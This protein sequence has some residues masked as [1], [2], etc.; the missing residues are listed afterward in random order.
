MP[1]ITARIINKH[2][3]E[4]NWAL[5][6]NFKPLAGEVIVYDVDSN[7]AYPRFKVG[8]GSTNVNDL[9]FST[10]YAGLIQKVESVP[11]SVNKNSPSFIQT[12]NGNVYYKQD[13]IIGTWVFNDTLGTVG[14]TSVD[15]SFQSTGTWNKIT[16][17]IDGTGS[18][19][20]IKYYKGT[21]TAPLT[22]YRNGSWR[23]DQ[24]KTITIVDVP[25][26]D[27]SQLASF[28][29]FLESNATRTDGGP[30]YIQL[31]SP[32][33]LATNSIKMDNGTVLGSIYGPLDSN[34]ITIPTISG[35]AGANGTDGL[36]ALTCSYII[37]SSQDPTGANAN[38]EIQ[39][40]YFNR[41]PKL[42][43]AVIVIFENT[44]SDTVYMC[45]ATVVTDYGSESE[46]HEIRIDSYT[47]ISGAPT[48]TT[49]FIVNNS[50]E[51]NTTTTFSCELSYFN[52]TPVVED[53]FLVLYNNTQNGSV[54]VCNAKAT[55][56][57]D[58]YCEFTLESFLRINGMN[59]F[60]T[61]QVSVASPEIIN[62]KL[63]SVTFSGS[64]YNGKCIWTDG[65]RIFE[66]YANY[67]QKQYNKVSKTFSNITWTGLPVSSLSFNPKF[68][69]T[70]GKSI[71]WKMG[72]YGLY[73]L[74]SGTYSWSSSSDY[75]LDSMHGGNSIWT[76]GVNL[77]AS[78]GHY[79][80][81]YDT[82]EGKWN[83][84]VTF[85]T[86][87]GSVLYPEPNAIGSMMF[88]DGNNVYFKQ[89]SE[90]EKVYRLRK[91]TYIWDVLY[92]SG[93]PSGSSSTTYYKA[94]DGKN[95]YVQISGNFQKYLIDF[96][97]LA[98]I[99]VSFF[100]APGSEYSSWN[101]DS[102]WTDGEEVYITNYG[103]NYRL[104]RDKSVIPVLGGN[105]GGLN[106]GP[107]DLYFTEEDPGDIVWAQDGST[108]S[109]RI[110][111][112]NIHSELVIRSANGS[113][114]AGGVVNINA[115]VKEKGNEVVTYAGQ[116]LYYEGFFDTRTF[117]I[118]DSSS[119]LACRKAYL[120][121]SAYAGG[122]FPFVARKKG[123]LTP[124]QQTISGGAVLISI[125]PWSVDWVDGKGAL[126]T[127]GYGISNAQSFSLSFGSGRW[128]VYGLGPED[129]T[130]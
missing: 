94:T 69:F 70:D 21:S 16:L 43:D 25:M 18:D 116:Q 11:T 93:F 3:T 5:A 72:A 123:S 52:R 68:V 87:D 19:D 84:S 76:D 99:P 1:N 2:D 8:D 109:A 63:E 106:L 65:E 129:Q 64:P 115:T 86:S 78:T 20:Y 126:S 13:S 92:I 49:T 34:D 80:W 85:T 58:S 97:N 111:Y 12:P 114:T 28:I 6:E 118:F 121:L 81:V 113:D 61:G 9:P 46:Y 62:N 107:N 96:V 90:G 122:N 74:N 79:Q 47:Q 53:T 83:T 77:F 10:D 91:G 128:F 88:S 66:S 119:K 105:Y 33:M 32:E 98:A 56:V 75:S 14:L 45:N 82:G 39:S 127:L 59:G 54:Y 50:S 55:D 51:P 60:G 22:A 41:T 23:N 48:L 31:L 103:S 95:V 27:P 38:W 29:T 42:N 117:T 73:K 7:H 108:E 57:T 36:D 35:P 89:A 67:T 71:Y 17:Y 110:Y 26:T 112:D 40:Q 15:I 120:V 100:T 101:I 24:C 125:S 37:K 102:M 104:I 130:P 30:V 124:T 4:A 44:N